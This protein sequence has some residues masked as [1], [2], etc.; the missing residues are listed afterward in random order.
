MSDYNY[1]VKIRDKEIKFR[2][3]KVKDKKAFLTA[4]ENEDQLGTESI[5]YDSLEDPN[6]PLS[7][8]EFK[9]VMMHIR[10]ESIGK[11]L[12]F[13]FTC[14]SCK[15]E[16]TY[17]DD[18]LQIQEAEFKPF[19]E[20]KSGNVSFK[21]GDIPNKE[22]YQDAI[23]QC[24]TY[25][26]KF[27]IDFLFHIKEMNGSD[28]FTFDSLYEYVNDLDVTIGENIFSQWNEMKLTFDNVHSLE[29]PHCG[30]TEYVQ[31]DELYGFFPDNWFE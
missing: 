5:V 12:S 14:D 9:Y 22:Y 7:E 28:A 23:R 21:M 25:E 6:I 3:W 11:E 20:I 24:T 30:S 4:L 17:T 10:R 27:F 31:F 1:S 15:G 18:I 13:D 8:E 2:K 29:C 19:G 26:E 16:Y